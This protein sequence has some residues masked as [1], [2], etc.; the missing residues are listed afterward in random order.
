MNYFY[1]RAYLKSFE[2]ASP[3]LQKFVVRTDQEIKRYLET[4]QA[5][6]GLRVKRIGPRTFEAR[7]SDKVRIVWVSEKERIVFVMFGNHT[8]VQNCLKSYR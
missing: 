2:E 1:K 6:F 7:V 4:G 5:A 3:S 8:Q